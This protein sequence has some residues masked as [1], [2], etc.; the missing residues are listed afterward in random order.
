LP[1]TQRA[2][3]GRPER[4]RALQIGRSRLG[5]RLEG[6]SGTSVERFADSSVPAGVF[7]G[8]VGAG[9]RPAIGRRPAHPDPTSASKNRVVDPK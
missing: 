5:G 8:W 4:V 9:C 1:S 7:D 6:V 3:Q 2:W